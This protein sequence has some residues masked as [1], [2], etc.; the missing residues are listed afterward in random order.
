MQKDGRQKRCGIQWVRT[1]SP[2]IYFL[3]RKQ[4]AVC[5]C[6]CVRR[7]LICRGDF[8]SQLT[9]G[10]AWNSRHRHSPVVNH[11]FS[12][13]FNPKHKYLFAINHFYFLCVRS[14]VF[15]FSD[16]FLPFF[17]FS[18]GE[19]FPCVSVREAF[20]AMR[21]KRFMQNGSCWA[22]AECLCVQR[23]RWRK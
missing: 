22:V 16:F 3:L 4:K 13:L 8:V 5:V 21:L 6:V 12:A 17:F 14:F 2:I 15:A 1:M 23:Q 19:I 18:L 11:W 9:I 20:D 7:A 10:D